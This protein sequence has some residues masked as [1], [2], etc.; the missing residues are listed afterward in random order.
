MAETS[1]ASWPPVF[2]GTSLRQSGEPQSAAAGGKSAT[3][4]ERGAATTIR[5]PL[6]CLTSE[7][8]LQRGAM[9]LQRRGQLF[10]AS[11]TGAAPVW[12]SSETSPDAA[13]AGVTPGRRHRPHQLEKIAALQ[14]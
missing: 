7:I 10:T 9:R 5:S 4:G 6:A 12:S 8:T 13:Q 3:S 11:A 14:M 2:P 1:S